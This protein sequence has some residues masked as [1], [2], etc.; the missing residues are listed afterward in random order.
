M[1]APAKKKPQEEKPKT[2]RDRFV[3]F[4]K[5]ISAAVGSVWAFMIAILI[6]VIWG[7]SGPLFGFSDT[8]Q[9]VINT[10]TTIVTFL[11]VF[12]IQSTQNRDAKAVHLKLD[13]L[14]R[15]H[16]GARNNLVDLE[17]LSEEDL[18]HLAKEF[19]SFREKACATIDRR[20]GESAKQ[21]ESETLDIDECADA[22]IGGTVPAK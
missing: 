1:H 13:E 12:M 21:G 6:V 20:R 7:V 4:S 5:A 2:F 15:S 11:M 3:D 14:I 16:K 19:T 10:G 17:D 22:E 9:L 8:W 18:E